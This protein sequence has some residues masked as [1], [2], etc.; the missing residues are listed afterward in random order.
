MKDEMKWLVVKVAMIA[1]M[2]GLL[3][4]RRFDQMS[5]MVS[6]N[7][8]LAMAAIMMIRRK[9]P[10]HYKKDEMTKKVSA[11]SASWSWMTTLFVVTFLFWFDY[12]ELMP[13][14][15]S[16]VITMIF[17]TMIASVLIFRAYFM[18]KGVM[19]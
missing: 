11:I 10:E 13:L 6:M 5:I 18:K 3:L 1:V 9:Y 2:L 7:I 4:W 16:Q 8:V 12:I 19:E 17:T 15:A 14:S